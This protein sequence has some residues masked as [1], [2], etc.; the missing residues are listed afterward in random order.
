MGAPAFT[1]Y[2][3]PACSTSRTVLAT[4]RGAGIEPCVVEY[5]EDPPDRAT[6]AALVGAMG[7]PVRA[8]LR[9]KEPAYVE[10]GLGD[11]SLGDDALLNAM[12]AHPILIQRP[13]VAAPTGTRICR[14]ADTVLELLP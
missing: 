3:N 8:L 13:I 11:P 12:L 10:L 4:I 6:L 2:H 14:P 1:I 7:L 9:E 5:L